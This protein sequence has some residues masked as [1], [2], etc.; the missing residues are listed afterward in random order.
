MMQDDYQDIINL[1][2]PVSKRHKRMDSATR[3]AQFLP[4][5]ALT[6]YDDAVK[7]SAR[8]TK[9]MLKLDPHAQEE[10]DR[11]LAVALSP[12]HRNKPIT[13]THFIP[14]RMKE[15]GEYRESKGCIL[16]MDEETHIILSTGE[17]IP[18]DAIISL[19]IG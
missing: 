17:R 5:A 16:K 13:I 8:I 1:P 2:H 4:F 6:G 3:A 10:L 11:T 12:E 18:L 19:K 9:E 15:G 14:D 7:E